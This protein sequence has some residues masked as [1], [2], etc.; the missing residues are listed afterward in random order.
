VGPNDPIEKVEQALSEAG[1][2]CRD[3]LLSQTLAPSEYKAL[4]KWMY[5]CLNQRN[6]IRRRV[7]VRVPGNSTKC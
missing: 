2:A 6:T 1:R 4:V 3:L 5:G 7:A